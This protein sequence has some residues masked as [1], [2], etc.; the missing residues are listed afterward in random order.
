MSPP[1]HVSGAPNV[2]G[3][4]VNTMSGLAI[5]A[6]CGT[7][8]ILG[9]SAHHAFTNGLQPSASTVAGGRHIRSGMRSQVRNSSTERFLHHKKL[10]SR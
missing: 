4:L 6:T 10:G 7:R 8:S 1:A 3:R 5:V 2:V 9:E